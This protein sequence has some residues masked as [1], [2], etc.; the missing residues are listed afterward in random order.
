MHLTG[1]DLISLDGVR[2]GVKGARVLDEAARDRGREFYGFAWHVL[3][4]GACPAIANPARGA[5]DPRQ[6]ESRSGSSNAAGVSVPELPI[7]GDCQRR[8]QHQRNNFFRV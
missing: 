1:G 4:M 7:P 5:D 2:L 3:E 6:R 8:E